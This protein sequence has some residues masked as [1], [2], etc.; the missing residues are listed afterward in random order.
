MRFWSASQEWHKGAV[1]MASFSLG[2][3]HRRI[4]LAPGPWVGTEAFH[5]HKYTARDRVAV[6][7]CGPT[8]K[9]G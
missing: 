8:E 5:G 3:V 1:G 2:G 4:E 7:A 9:K 6:F